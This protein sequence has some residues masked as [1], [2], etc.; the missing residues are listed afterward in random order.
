MTKYFNQIEEREASNDAGYRG[1][2]DAAMENPGGGRQNTESI[3]TRSNPR[4]R[5][6]PSRTGGG[7]GNGRQ[8]YDRPK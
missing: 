7:G 3:D 1:N 4:Q 2:A 6:N 5:Q 8:S